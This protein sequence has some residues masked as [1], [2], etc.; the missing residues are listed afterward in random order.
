MNIVN[1][2]L[3]TIASEILTE[4]LGILG[5]IILEETLEQFNIADGELS[6][7]AIIPFLKLLATN[8]PKDVDRK[9]II[10]SIRN[11]YLAQ[12]KKA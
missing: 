1:N 2:Y 10:L 12:T 7:G 8:L 5:C 3:Q 9:N 4:E 6:S 11:T